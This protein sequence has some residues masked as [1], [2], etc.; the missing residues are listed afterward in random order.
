[1]E[2]HT[3]DTLEME[4]VGLSSDG[5]AVGRSAEGMTVFVRGGVPGQ[6]VV[7]RLTAVK[8]RMAEAE[9]V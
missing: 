5:R 2:Y 7:A 8:K 3:G 1:M 9:L 6:I 4:L